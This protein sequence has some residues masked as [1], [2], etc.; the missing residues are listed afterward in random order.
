MLL[1]S[2]RE[3]EHSGAAIA[4][5]FG[6]DAAVLDVPYA[7]GKWTGHQVLLHLADTETVFHERLRRILASD[8]GLLVPFDMDG[9][10]TR[11]PARS[12]PVMGALFTATRAAIVE[13][14]ATLR[15]AD[16]ARLGWHQ[17]RGEVTV[18]AQLRMIHWHADHHAAQVRAV[19][20]GR[21]WVKV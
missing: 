11:L 3:L 14:A 10:A 20:E 4:P 8:R 13:L 5:L 9:W 21:V 15:P 17:A 6:T 16:L 2:A 19:I 1:T 12:L 7:P 18:P